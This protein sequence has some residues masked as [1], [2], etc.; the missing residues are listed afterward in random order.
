LIDLVENGYYGLLH[1]F[2][3]QRRNSQRALPP[4]SLRYVDSPRSSRP[5][6]S[7]MNPVMQIGEPTL[8]PV[9][10]LFPRDTVHSGCSL[11]LQCVKA[12]PQTKALYMLEAQCDR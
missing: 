4:V 2:V 8:Q 6:R 10:I 3:F 12:V 1:N 7:T 11:S 9:F 5:V